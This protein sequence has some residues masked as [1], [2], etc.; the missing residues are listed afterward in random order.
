[1]TC[2]SP[3]G[4]LFI[5][6][7]IVSGRGQKKKIHIHAQRR[8]A[9]LDGNGL[10]NRKVLQIIEIEWNVIVLTTKRSQSE[11]QGSAQGKKNAI[12]FDPKQL[13]PFERKK[14]AA[15]SRIPGIVRIPGL[16]RRYPK[17]HRFKKCHHLRYSNKS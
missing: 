13:L 4:V 10:E 5:F 6:Q 16:T 2:C 14:P 11:S 7:T 12:F 1:M 9:R 15:R 17:D 3:K 8:I